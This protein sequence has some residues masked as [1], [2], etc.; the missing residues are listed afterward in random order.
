MD[1]EC[2]S[3]RIQQEYTFRHRTA[4]RTPAER[5]QEYLTSRKE[6]IDP[7]K[8]RSGKG[9]KEKNKSVSSVDLPLAGGGTEAGVQ[10][11][12]QCNCLSQRRNI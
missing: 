8:T 6:Y 2:I 11:P 1:V 7:H 5:G 12:Y 4:C 3:S 9:T 10:S